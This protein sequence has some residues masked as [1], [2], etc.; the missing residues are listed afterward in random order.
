MNVRIDRRLRLGTLALAALCAGGARAADTEPGVWWEHTIEAEMKGMSVPATTQKVC[1]PKGGVREPPGAGNDD[2]C[3]VTD[4]KNAGAKMTWKV[5]CSG[6]DPMTGEGEMVRGKDRYDGKMSMHSKQ[7][8]MSMKMSGKLVGGE[9]DA[10]A[11]KKQVAA[12]Q[13][14]QAQQQKQADQTMA[15][16]CDKAAEEVQ[17]RAFAGSTA[18]CK[19]PEQAAAV[20]ARLGTRQGYTAYRKQAQQDPEVSRLAKDLCKKDPETARAALCAQAAKDARGDRTPDDLLQFLGQSCPDEARALAKKECAG[21][22]F[23]GMPDG[24]RQIC[25]QYAREELAAD[26]AQPKPA[27]AEQPSKKSSQDDALQQG[28]K[29][30]KKLW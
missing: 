8:D 21:R 22:S 30:F 1:V 25:V 19:K 10:G 7:G 17:L 6:P 24:F 2:R 16:V 11:V 20:C 13:A 4:V 3:K 15:Q 18:L 28:K 5:V 9:C 12:V 23:T 29:L 26:D 14:Q 27:A